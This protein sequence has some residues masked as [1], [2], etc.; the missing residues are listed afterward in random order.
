MK[1]IVLFALSACLLIATTTNF[2]A[3]ANQLTSVTASFRCTSTTP[4]DFGLNPANPCGNGDKIAGDY[5]GAYIGEPINSKTPP[6]N[7]YI[8]QSGQFWFSQQ[9]GSGRSVFFDFSDAIPPLPQPLLRSFTSA[10]STEFQP[11][12]LASPV[13][14][15]NGLWGM[16]LN[17]QVSGTL[18]GDFKNAYDS[19]R[20]TIRFNPSYGPNATYLTITC[21]RAGAN[22]CTA[23]MIEATASHAAELIASTTSG[24]YVTYDEG[25]YVMPFEIT[26]TYP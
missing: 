16:A 26:V 15:T 9:P 25:A 4:P 19:Y 17:Q 20:W 23:W 7:A 3:A 1:R 11:N 6:N 10:W 22:T 2:H 24:K 18:K 5:K 21:T 12:W 14:V 8:D 13:G